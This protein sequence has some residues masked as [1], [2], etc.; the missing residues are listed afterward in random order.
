MLSYVIDPEKNHIDNNFKEILEEQMGNKVAAIDSKGGV[1]YHR[2]GEDYD[3]FLQ[4]FILGSGGVV[5]KWEREEETDNALV[6]RGLG[7][8]SQK[9]IKHCWETNRTFYA[10]D[11]GY[12]GNDK[13]KKWHRVTKNA[14]QIG[15][16][17]RERDSARLA[18]LNYKFVPF[19]HGSKILIC[20]PSEK[21]MKLWNQPSPEDWTQNI[22]NE[23]RQYTDR[24]V[25]VRLKPIRRERIS[26]KTMEMALAD[27]V[28]CLI[29]YNSIAATE[30]L[31][32]G[33][34]AITLGPNAA[35]VLC[36]TNLYEVENLYTPSA[37]EMYAFAC[38]LSYA[39]FTQDEMQNGTAW[40]IVNE[41]S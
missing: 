10:I 22:I 2:K 15:G 5:S 17:I 11:T 3:S 23:L 31:L 41:S 39:Q 6:I 35:S 33:K 34:P 37:D 38:H 13:G 21:V 36:N 1:G 14:L 12:M 26:N 4:S 30:A 18:K 24:P 28:H 20:P 25:E 8:G 32:L 27:D 16:P 29:T 7:G 19:T 9:A 40:R